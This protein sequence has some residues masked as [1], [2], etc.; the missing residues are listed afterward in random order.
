MQ[1]LIIEVRVNEYAS[2][3]GNPRVPWLSA[4]IARDAAECRAAGA[5]ILHFHG[6]GPDGAPDHRFE[7]YRD[8]IL[9]AREACDILLHPTLG[10]NERRPAFSPNATVRIHSQQRAEFTGSFLRLAIH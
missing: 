9:A 4:E 1:K 6:R 5:T 7:C 2:R 3:R 10:A 8:V